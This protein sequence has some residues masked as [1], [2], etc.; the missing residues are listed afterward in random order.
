MWE[1]KATTAKHCGFN[2]TRVGKLALVSKLLSTPDWPVWISI[3]FVDSGEYSM[4]N[5]SIGDLKGEGGPE[6]TF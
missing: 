3:Q 5:R 2:Y 6:S 1:S 4:I